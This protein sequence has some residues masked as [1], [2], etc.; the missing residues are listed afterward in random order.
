MKGL[1]L[2]LT[3]SKASPRPSPPTHLNWI[4]ATLG[5]TWNS[6]WLEFLQ[7]L[8]CKLGHKVALLCRWD[9]PTQPVYNL[10]SWLNQY[11]YQLVQTYHLD[12][13]RGICLGCL[14]TGQCLE[15][16]FG[17]VESGGCVDFSGQIRYIKIWVRAPRKPRR[18]LHLVNKILEVIKIHNWRLGQIREGI[19]RI[20]QVRKSQP[21]RGQ[22]RSSQDRL[23]Q[24]R[25]I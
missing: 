18:C 17:Y 3:S 2:R 7:V 8:T 20:G 25:S 4:F 15:G 1:S 6:T 16:T 11:Y 19:F 5:P 21:R 14:D 13:V 23:S 12:S 24:K 10:K 9:P 22:V